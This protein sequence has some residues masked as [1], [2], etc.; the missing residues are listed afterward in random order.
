MKQPRG[1]PL[2]AGELLPNTVNVGYGEHILYSGPHRG[3]LPIWRGGINL[4]KVL[5][6]L[7]K[8]LEVTPFMVESYGPIQ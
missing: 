4:F 6:D 2:H 7:F 8:C 1:N 5:I 3:R